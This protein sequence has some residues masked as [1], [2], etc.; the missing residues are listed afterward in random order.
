RKRRYE[1][2]SFFDKRTATA[3]ADAATAPFAASIDG[4]IRAL[5]ASLGSISEG[6]RSP[7]MTHVQ[8]AITNQAEVGNVTTQHS[9][10]KIPIA[11][12]TTPDGVAFLSSAMAHAGDYLEYGAGGSTITASAV[13][14]LRNIVSVES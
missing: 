10:Q 8:G 6:E 12:H 14:T 2:D 9:K 11:P 3:G 1:D 13:S 4:K 7:K 5:E